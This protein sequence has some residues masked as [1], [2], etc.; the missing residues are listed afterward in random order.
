MN[1]QNTVTSNKLKYSLT[2]ITYQELL[3]DKEIK[4]SLPLIERRF[5]KHSPQS[6]HSRSATEVAAGL[7]I[8]TDEINRIVIDNVITWTFQTES[9]VLETSDFENFLVKK[10]NGVF[11]YFLVSYEFTDLTDSETL[12]EK[13]TSYVISEEYLSLEDL[14]LSSRDAF[15]WVFPNDG[16]GTGSG[17]C[18]SILV[19]DHCNLGGNADGHWPV[20]QNDGVT[21]CSG[22]PLLYIDFSHCENYG[23]PDSPVGDPVGGDDGSNGDQLIGGGGGNSG[24]DGDTTL[25]APVGIMHS[26]MPCDPRPEG[27]LNG[28]CMLEFYEVC[29][30][31]IGVRGLSINILNQ[32]KDFINTNGCNEQTQNFIELAIDALDGDGIDDGEVDFEE[33]IINEL[34]G[35]EKCIYNKLK[36]LDLFK[37]TIKKFEDSDTYNLILKYGNCSNT[38]I[39]CTGAGDIS[40]G[41]ISIIF[42][43]TVNSLPLEFAS[44]ILHEGIHAELFKYIDE[45][46][47][48]L[49]PNEREN[50]LFY[51]FEAKKSVDPRYVDALAQHQHM[52]DNYARPIAEAIRRLDNNSYP[53]E[54]YMGYGWDGLRKYGYDGYWD[55]GNW[56]DL[57]KSTSTEY[58]QNQKT[59]NDNTNVQSNDCEN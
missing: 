3:A 50:L 26:E 57:D 16:S 44:I 42:E 38:D 17:P 28:D 55:N 36:N 32:I 19:Y 8:F 24:G 29:L 56:V 40:N 37:R 7:T 14:N 13:A 10:H 35:E 48:G 53:L 1:P 23:V 4:P 30:I 46:T 33:K 18:E 45:Y 2:K 52:A 34:T 6:I 39:A 12:Y 31:D 20:L 43:T 11:T 25:T 51:Y 49:D 54:Y 21:Y 9:P 41:N 47:Q 22:S 15:D 58:Y 27:D 5:S 59:V